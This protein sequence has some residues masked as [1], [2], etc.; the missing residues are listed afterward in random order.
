MNNNIE[1]YNRFVISYFPNSYFL[2]YKINDRKAF[3]NVLNKCITLKKCLATLQHITKGQKHLLDEIIYQFLSILYIV[4]GNDD[5]QYFSIMRALIENF[6]RLFLSTQTEINVLKLKSR[7][8][9]YSKLKEEIKNTDGYNNNKNKLDI[10]FSNYGKFSQY[11]HD[12]GKL[13][14]SYLAYLEQIRTSSP[15]ISLTTKI[16]Q[17]D[18]HKDFIKK[19]I[20][21]ALNANTKTISTE[22]LAILERV[23]GEREYN[24]LPIFEHK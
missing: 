7:S 9:N 6:L 8:Y 20:Y 23:L 13:S 12:K 18:Q 21:P 16:N 11:I 1:T 4:P 19:V 15:G 10:M 17:L 2:K 22:E 3:F 5:F 14:K 24:C